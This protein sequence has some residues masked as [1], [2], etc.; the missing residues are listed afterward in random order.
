LRC[1][2]GEAP[3]PGSVAVGGGRAGLDQHWLRPDG[4]EGRGGGATHEVERLNDAVGE[5]GDEADTRG[6]S[7][8]I[9]RAITR[10]RG[11]D[12]QTG[13]L[14]RPGSGEARPVLGPAR[15]AWLG[16]RAG[17]SKLAGLIPCPSPAR[18]SP[19]WVGTARLTRKKRTE[20]GLNRPKN[21]F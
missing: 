8:G 18:S 12:G 5:V 21:M 20:S 4:G 1:D 3:K 19:K 15:Q 11:R 14:A 9:R 13:R 2:G 16:N 6:A 17:S 10:E 7:P